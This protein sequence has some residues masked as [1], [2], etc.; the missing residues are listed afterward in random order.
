MVAGIQS[1]EGFAVSPDGGNICIFEP[2]QLSLYN[3]TT[4]EIYLQ[5]HFGD[6]FI[7]DGC[8]VG[9]KIIITMGKRTSDDW[10][11]IRVLLSLKKFK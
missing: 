1:I 11:P 6:V 9:D 4:D 10:D 2:Q 3:I 7:I 5:K 8:W